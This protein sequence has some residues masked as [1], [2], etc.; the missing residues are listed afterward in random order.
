MAKVFLFDTKTT[1]LKLT[2]IYD[3]FKWLLIYMVFVH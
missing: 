1:N 3:D 2:N